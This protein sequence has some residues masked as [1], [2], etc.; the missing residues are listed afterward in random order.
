MPCGPRPR[1]GRLARR[2]SFR[3]LVVGE[4]PP[5]HRPPTG[6][7]GSRERQRLSM[8][9]CMLSESSWTLGGAHAVRR[10]VG[11]GRALPRY[12]TRSA[13]SCPPGGPRGRRLC[14][15]RRSARPPQTPTSTRTT[16]TRRPGVG[17]PSWAEHRRL[18]GHD[19]FWNPA[20]ALASGAAAVSAAAAGPLALRCLL[21]FV[22]FWP[23][24][25]FW[26]RPGVRHVTRQLVGN[27]GA[28]R[29]R[30]GV[31]LRASLVDASA[32]AGPPAPRHERL[33]L[34]KLRAT[35]A[36]D[37]GR[38]QSDAPDRPSRAQER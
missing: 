7:K 5:H 17:S 16:A 29:V 9:R 31:T 11:G 36:P 27:S 4:T 24:I 22:E 19:G 35:L 14:S 15:T 10:P 21:A 13:S 8:R 6:E 25:V 37:I 23:N 12:G 32:S 18:R 30:R 26:C 3:S 1:R 28:R 34:R 20:R 33:G 2:P 38:S